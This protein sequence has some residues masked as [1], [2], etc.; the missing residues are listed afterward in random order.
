MKENRDMFYSDYQASGFINPNMMNGFNP[1]LMNIPNNMN[2]NLY[3][4]T[5]YTENRILKLERQVK[6]LESRITR[7]ENLSGNTIEDFSSTSDIY[8]I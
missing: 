1:G 6:R 7:L 3:N 4:D 5:S 2:N 8:M